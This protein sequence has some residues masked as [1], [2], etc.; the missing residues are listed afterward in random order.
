MNVSSQEAKGNLNPL[1]VVGPAV[2]DVLAGMIRSNERN[3]LD[4]GSIAYEIDSILGWWER[5]GGEI[6]LLDAYGVLGRGFL[7]PYCRE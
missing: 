6:S 7:E 3:C 5:K 2:V 4:L 1:S